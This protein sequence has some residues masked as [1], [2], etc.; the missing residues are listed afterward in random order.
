MSRVD[1]LAN[2]V[3]TTN[4]MLLVNEAQNIRSVYIQV[5]DICELALKSYLQANVN[6][7]QP[8]DG[9]ASSGRPWFKG[10]GTVIEEARN[11]FPHNQQLSDLLDNF[12]DRREERNHFF[13]DHT[14]SGLTVTPEKCLE[15]L[16]DLYDLLN[17]LFPDFTDIVEA[18][19]ILRTQIAVIRLKRRMWQDGSFNNRYQAILQQWKHSEDTNYLPVNGVVLLRHP[20]LGYEFCVVYMDPRGLYD[21]L[22]DAGL[23]V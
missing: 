8:T 17:I 10:F 15:A 18:N 19:S 23:I 13:H 5:D 2:L 11:E 9:T 1:D 6:N 14:L 12:E 4:D 22:D 21:E 20:C 7:W 3:K 16:C